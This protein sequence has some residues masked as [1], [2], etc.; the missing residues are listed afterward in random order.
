MSANDVIARL[1]ELRSKATPG[2]WLAAAKPSSIV[3]WPIIAPRS[4]GAMSVCNVH[5]GHEYSAANAAA[6][7]AAMNSLDALLEC[8]SA[9]EQLLDDLGQLA[10]A[11][12][13]I[14]AVEEARAAL[15]ALAEGGGE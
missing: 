3:G 4:P 13:S 6:I 7:V 14:Q 11:E 8:A 10:P 15:Q 9:L 2:A 1:R 5:T 12:P